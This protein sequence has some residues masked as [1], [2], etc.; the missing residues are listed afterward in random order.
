[1]TST[2]TASGAVGGMRYSTR[3]RFVLAG[4]VQPASDWSGRYMKKT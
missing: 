3:S 1:M 4:K 2:M